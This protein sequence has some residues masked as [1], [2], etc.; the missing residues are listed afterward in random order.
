MQ[1]NPTSEPSFIGLKLVHNQ[2]HI[3]KAFERS[4][5]DFLPILPLGSK[6][7]VIQDYLIK[8][9]GG[10]ISFGLL[11]IALRRRFERKFRH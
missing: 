8:V 4:V 5:A 1:A 2:T 7:V 6:E 10:A 11:A 9:I 3:W